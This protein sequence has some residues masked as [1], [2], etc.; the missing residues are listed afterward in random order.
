MQLSY[1]KEGYVNPISPYWES[2]DDG[3]L[4]SLHLD[5]V[6]DFETDIHTSLMKYI[7]KVRH[8]GTLEIVGL[9]LLAVARDLVITRTLDVPSAAK[10]LFDGRDAAIDL[11]TLVKMVE[12]RGFKVIQK[13][14][15]GYSYF[16]SAERL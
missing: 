14:Y 9:D 3:E 1:T 15:D 11:P 8:G 2:I 4:D 12:S 6:L 13:R 10:L 7:S 5:N 16:L